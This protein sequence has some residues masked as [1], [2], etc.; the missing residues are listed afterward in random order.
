MPANVSDRT[1]GRELWRWRL[2]DQVLERS[3]PL[4]VGI[5]NVTG[6]SMYEGARSGTPEQAIEDGRRLVDQWFDMLD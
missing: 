2:S 3:E 5:V 4:A 1:R 6:D